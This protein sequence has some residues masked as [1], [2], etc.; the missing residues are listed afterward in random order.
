[1]K[2]HGLLQQVGSLLSEHVILGWETNSY[3]L[4]QT[5]PLVQKTCHYMFLNDIDIQIKSNKGI[6]HYLLLKPRATQ[7]PVVSPDAGLKFEDIGDHSSD[8]GIDHILDWKLIPAQRRAGRCWKKTWCVLSYQ[9][10]SES[11]YF[12]KSV[13]QLV[14]EAVVLKHFGNK[15]SWLMNM[16]W[17][18]A[19][20]VHIPNR[21]QARHSWKLVPITQCPSCK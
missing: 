3:S 5:S 11:S 12:E 6:Q 17:Q 20:Y 2:F 1:M 7:K 19:L 9:S 21:L 13:N 15:H 8:S 18:S 4:P 10:P 14:I 16:F